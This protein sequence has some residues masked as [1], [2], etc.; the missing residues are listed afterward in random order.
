[1]PILIVVNDYQ[2]QCWN[3][4]V[5]VVSLDPTAT[6]PVLRVYFPGKQLG[7][8]P[9]R[10]PAHE[11]VFAM[12]IHKSQGSELDRV[13]CILPENPTPIVTRELLYTAVTRAKKSL[14]VCA[15]RDVLAA[16]IKTP[17][18]RDSGLLDRLRYGAEFP[19]DDSSSIARPQ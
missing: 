12:T 4:D 2:L 7:I 15:S 9:A 11:T 16:A 18:E 10:L 13:L 19:G 5:G 14:V 6:P 8:S 1:L 3:G 17:L